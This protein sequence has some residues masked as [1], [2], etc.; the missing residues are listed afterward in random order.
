M[1]VGERVPHVRIA[2]KIFIG[3]KD[4][5]SSMGKSLLIYPHFNHHIYSLFLITQIAK[6][7]KG[8][9]RL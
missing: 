3:K 7:I 9:P 8:I 6:I 1:Y 4:K 5:H 2:E